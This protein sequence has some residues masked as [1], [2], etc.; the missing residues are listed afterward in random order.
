MFAKVPSDGTPYPLFAFCRSGALEFLR[1]LACAIF[2]Q[3]RGKREPN[4]QSLFSA[5]GDSSG[6]PCLPGLS[7]LRC[8]LGV[9]LGMM[10]YYKRM[11]TVH[12]LWLPLFILL[13]LCASWASDSG[14]R[15]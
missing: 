4:Y 8:F 3:R 10:A 6:R 5:A 9:L 12:I 14:S 1:D 11:P 15:P 2:E 7:I 13:E